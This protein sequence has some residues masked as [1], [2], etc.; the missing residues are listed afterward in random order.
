MSLLPHAVREAVTA[1]LGGADP[2]VT[3]LTGGDVNRAA[4]VEAG[5]ERLVVKWQADAPPGLFDAEA[6]G[7]RRLREAGPIRVP[8]VIAFDDHA[9]PSWLALEYVPA[10]RPADPRRFARRFG[11]ALAALHR[12]TPAPDGRF[13]LDRDN[14]LG[15][16]PQRNTPTPRWPDFYRDLRLLPQYDRARGLGLLTPDRERLLER[17]MDEISALMDGFA[18]APVLVHGDLWS[19]NF[20]CAA[21]DE[22]VLIDPAVCY[23]EREVEMAYTELFGGFPPGF[24]TAYDAAFPLDDGYARR[25][26]LHQVYP[27][28]I[29]LNHF[30]ETYGPALRPRP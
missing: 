30:G 4:L 23:A 24:H 13:G 26:P 5:G 16:Q 14:F 28:L 27:L 10:S 17:V 11:E 21:D 20:L 15:S 8:A 12:D 25:R 3:P 2:R 18:P 19:G 9:S 22:P 6:D 29:H 1:L 7:L